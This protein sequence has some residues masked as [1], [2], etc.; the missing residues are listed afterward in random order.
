MLVRMQIATANSTIVQNLYT[1]Y[2]QDN[3]IILVEAGEAADF[4][5]QSISHLCIVLD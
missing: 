1:P 5:E 4:D 3:R 2:L